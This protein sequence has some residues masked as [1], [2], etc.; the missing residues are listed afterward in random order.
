MQQLL[1]TLHPS[2]AY[3]HLASSCLTAMPTSLAVQTHYLAIFLG[4][5]RRRRAGG[6]LSYVYLTHP[7][8][9]SLYT[10]HLAL[11]FGIGIDGWGHSRCLLLS[12]CIS[13]LGKHRW[14]RCLRQRCATWHGTGSSSVPLAVW[15]VTLLRS[16]AA[17][18]RLV[19][20]FNKASVYVY[21]L[22]TVAPPPP[23]LLYVYMSPLALYTCLYMQI[24][25][26]SSR[27]AAGCNLRCPIR[28]REASSVT[29]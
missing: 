27:N 5:R 3:L 29:N 21:V 25:L 4:R 10:Q 24:S 23:T 20:P 6:D 19:K 16:L 9:F 12:Q 15:L 8:A 17:G 13:M 2:R 1:A 11:G 7:S 22:C 14:L 28:H 18:E 26:N